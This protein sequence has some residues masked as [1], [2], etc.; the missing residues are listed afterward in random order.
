MQILTLCLTKHKSN[1]DY[2]A[3]PMMTSQVLKSV[4]FTK[5]QK[6]RYLENETILSSNKKGYFMAKNCFVSGNLST[7]KWCKNHDL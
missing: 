3:M 1:F 6:C 4:D 7:E 2:V 5:T